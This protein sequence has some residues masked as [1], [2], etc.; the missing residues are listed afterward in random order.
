MRGR[1]E[2]KD[3]LAFALRKAHRDFLL[4]KHHHGMQCTQPRFTPARLNRRLATSSWVAALCGSFAF[5]AWILSFQ[6][7]RLSIAAE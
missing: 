1:G 5:G 3:K 4:F 6:Q 7:L 2:Y